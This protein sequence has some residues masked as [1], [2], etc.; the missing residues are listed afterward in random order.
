MP[1]VGAL[2]SS[3]SWRRRQARKI[4]TTS[5]KV[6]GA[7]RVSSK[8]RHLH[9]G[10]APAT[11]CSLRSPS[12]RR[13]HVRRRVLV[14]HRARGAAALQQR[15]LRCGA[16]RLSC[17]CAATPRWHRAPAVTCQVHMT[18]AARDAHLWTCPR[19]CCA[20]ATRHASALFQ[21]QFQ[22]PVLPDFRA[23]CQVRCFEAARFATDL[24]LRLRRLRRRL[25]SLESDPAALAHLWRCPRGVCRGYF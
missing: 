7:F 9:P 1:E 2:V 8:S 18:A 22:P 10:E 24:R 11:R 4:G 19:R 25:P 20:A 12:A 5:N 21:P 23:R 6:F 15:G 3:A 14:V 16:T 13:T 17:R